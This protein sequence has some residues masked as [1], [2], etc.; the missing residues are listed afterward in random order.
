MRL[1]IGAVKGGQTG[2]TGEAHG[3][4]RRIDRK[5]ILAEIIAQNLPQPL[6]HRHIAGAG[7]IVKAGEA[8]ATQGKAHIRMG[9]GQP[10]D[11][12]HHRQTFGPLGFQKFQPRG[13]AG[14]QVAHLDLRAFGKRHGFRGRFDA[15]INLNPEAKIAAPCPCANVEMR[16]RTD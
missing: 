5:R 3:F 4:A 7:R 13:Q 16:H 2:K 8:L 12:I 15:K 11:A 6:Q 10:F 9:H 1:C 14:K